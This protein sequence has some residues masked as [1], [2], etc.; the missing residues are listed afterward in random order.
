MLKAMT[1]LVVDYFSGVPSTPAYSHDFGGPQCN[2]Y[3]NEDGT[4]TPIPGG[5]PD[6]RPKDCSAYNPMYSAKRTVAITDNGENWHP[7]GNEWLSCK[8]DKTIKDW[9]I[10]KDHSIKA[11]T[12]VTGK[13]E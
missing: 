2:V 11:C 3:W 10:S 7:T 9:N 6:V 12:N 1:D 13:P 5:G 4:F 8:D